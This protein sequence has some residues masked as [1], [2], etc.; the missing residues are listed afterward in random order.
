VVTSEQ[1]DEYNSAVLDCGICAF[2]QHLASHQRKT[3][4]AAQRRTGGQ[5]DAF[6]AMQYAKH[7]CR[8]CRL[9]NASRR[10]LL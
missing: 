2:L 1:H 10:N 8:E 4:I 5:S 7:N 9:K 6:D 3:N